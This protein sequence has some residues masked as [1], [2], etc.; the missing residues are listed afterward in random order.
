MSKTVKAVGAVSFALIG[1]AALSACASSSPAASV[2][3][4]LSPVPAGRAT[5]SNGLSYNGASGTT[6]G[7][8]STVTPHMLTDTVGEVVTTPQALIVRT[9]SVT[10][11]VS[12]KH[13]VDVFDDI[14]TDVDNLGGYVQ[15]S[16]STSANDAGG[17]SLVVRV[18]SARFGSLVTELDSLGRVE[19]QSENGNDVTGESIDLQAQLE[20]LKSEEAALRALVAKATSV[21]AILEVQNQLF[22][23]EG[24]IQQ[25]TAQE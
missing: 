23:V 25:L 18:P 8:H 1:G 4:S 16:S 22:G 10:L 14:S 2:A 21:S 20:N 12:A 6:A 15:S 7:P 9:G 3:R 24:D 11:G 13:V 5:S 17:A 19:G